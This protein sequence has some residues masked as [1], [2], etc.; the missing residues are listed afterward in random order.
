MI[1]MKCENRSLTRFI[2]VC[3][4]QLNFV[5]YISHIAKSSF[6]L[7]EIDTNIKKKLLKN[8]IYNNPKIKKIE[9]DKKFE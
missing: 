7:K 3:H 9:H 8:L 4:A 6:F 2:T 5:Y 1:S